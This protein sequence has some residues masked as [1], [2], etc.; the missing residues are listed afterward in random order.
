MYKPERSQGKRVVKLVNA[1]IISRILIVLGSLH[2]GSLQ[3][4]I[5]PYM[6]SFMSAII[7]FYL[8]YIGAQTAHLINGYMVQRR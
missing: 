1:A 2:F 6:V 4:G 7:C 3:K 5:I 8:S